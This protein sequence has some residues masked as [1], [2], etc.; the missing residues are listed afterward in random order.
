MLG[1]V[2][3]LSA[4]K[5]AGF[6]RALVAAGAAPR[7]VRMLARGSHAMHAEVTPTEGRVPTSRG[8]AAD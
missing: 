7:L 3:A 4:R 5:D 1:G 2:Q 6:K 8:K